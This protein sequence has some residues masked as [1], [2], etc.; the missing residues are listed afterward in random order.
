[1]F[2]RITITSII[3]IIT[4]A[5]TSPLPPPFTSYSRDRIPH[6]NLEEKKNFSTF[7]TGYTVPPPPAHHPPTP[8]PPFRVLTFVSYVTLCANQARE[9][10]AS[11][12]YKSSSP[13]I[14]NFK[15]NIKSVE[16]K[17]IL[18]P[19]PTPGSYGHPSSPL[20]FFFFFSLSLPTFQTPPLFSPRR[21]L[22]T[23]LGYVKLTPLF[24]LV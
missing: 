7:M 20:F 14:T 5:V 18:N 19:P 11:L 17:E 23:N 8:F 16:K 24:T 6:R 4:T 2:P 9:E 10:E 13:R 12:S 22:D 15:L 3:T 1:M 21:T